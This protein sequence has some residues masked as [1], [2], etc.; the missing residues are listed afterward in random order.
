VRPE[1]KPS[2]TGKKKKKKQDRRPCQA[3][4][5]APMEPLG[6]ADGRAPKGATT[7][8]SCSM[9]NVCTLGTAYVN[10]LFLSVPSV[11]VK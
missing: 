11:F 9:D 7:A 4:M 2:T 3:A 8:Y 10:L 6:N 1:F 5:S